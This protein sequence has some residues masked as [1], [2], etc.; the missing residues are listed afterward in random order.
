[1]SE[2]SGPLRAFRAF[3]SFAIASP[4]SFGDQCGNGPVS[5]A[6]RAAATAASMSAVD[7]SGTRPSATSV[8]EDRTSSVALARAGW[9]PPPMKRSLRS[10]KPAAALNRPPRPTRSIV[11]AA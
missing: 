10:T 8:D 3:E 7:A 5:K 9:K 6:A 1:M 2:A 4:R 11:R